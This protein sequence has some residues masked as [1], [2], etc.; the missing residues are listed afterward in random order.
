[1]NFLLHRELAD[2]DTGSEIAGIGAMLPDLWRMADRRVRPS[3]EPVD[4]E[5]DTPEARALLA[6]IAHHLEVDAW[7]HVSPFFVEGERATLAALRSS[8]A[9]APRLGLFAHVVWEMC[10]DGALARRVGHDRVLDAL[11]RGF[12]ASAAAARA[13]VERHHFDRVARAPGDRDVFDARM[14]RIVAEL[15]HGAWTHGYQ[16]GAGLADRLT[17]VRVRLGLPPLSPDDRERVAGALDALAPRADAALAG[18]LA[19][20]DRK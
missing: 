2:R 20:V 18:I 4:T 13:A 7:F 14:A 15:S 17:G 10:L 11:R 12:D 1:M 8:G 9:G 19:T 5:H 6:G 3:R 16:H